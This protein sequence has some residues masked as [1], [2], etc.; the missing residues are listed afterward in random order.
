MDLNHKRLWLALL[1][2]LIVLAVALSAWGLRDF[3]DKAKSANAN[4]GNAVITIC[5]KT[6]S[7]KNPYVEITLAESALQDGHAEHAD[8]IIPA[9][10]DGCP[11]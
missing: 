4:T 10:K 7:K 9:P 5:H 3:N 2:G 1:A 8:D 6:G 11:K